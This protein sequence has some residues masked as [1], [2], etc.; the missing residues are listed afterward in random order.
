MAYYHGS[1]KPHEVGSVLIAT[2]RKTEFS[3]RTSVDGVGFEDLVESFRPKDA[4]SRLA[5][6]YSVEHVE[7]VNVAG[8]AEDYVYAVAPLGRVTRVYFAWLSEILGMFFDGGLARGN[9]R[10]AAYA[11]GYWSGAKPPKSARHGVVVAEVLS[12][13][14][15]ILERVKHASRA[16]VARLRSAKRRR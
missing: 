15:Q 5:S 7:D 8:G 13:G 9:D 1:S 14:V 4:P 6:I 2:P 16:R 12:D 3:R 10:M 11:L